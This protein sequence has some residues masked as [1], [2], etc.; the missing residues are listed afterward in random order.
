MCCCL[1]VVSVFDC[2]WQNGFLP[3]EGCFIKLDDYFSVEEPRPVAVP[4]VKATVT[5]AEH[6]SQQRQIVSNGTAAAAADEDAQT[7]GSSSE[8]DSST[9][10]EESQQP[11]SRLQRTQQ[12]SGAAA[13]TNTQRAP[14]PS[15]TAATP[16]KQAP[17]SQRRSTQPK[18][19]AQ[20]QS[21]PQSKQLRR[22]P[23]SPERRS[24]EVDNNC[25]RVS[26]ATKAVLPEDVVTAVQGYFSMQF[27]QQTAI[28]LNS[29]GSR[30][31]TIV[32]KLTFL[33]AVAHY[34]RSA[35]ASREAVIS[36]LDTAAQD[37]VEFVT[38]GKSTAVAVF[39]VRCRCFTVA[40]I[41]AAAVV[42]W[43][44]FVL[45]WVLAVVV[46][47]LLL[48]LLLSQEICLLRSYLICRKTFL[49]M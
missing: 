10:A 3:S 46:F 41:G 35:T 30:S 6:G 40:R 49:C 47:L 29:A 42:L 27:V 37:F 16:S 19:S 32:R 9:D 39:S 7:H 38:A 24:P 31:G 28:A 36:H 15:G 13:T 44:E 33:P 2:I 48:L 45:T 26:E 23:V 34:L 22:D 14:P 20:K 1:F 43:S 18:Q 21:A 17:S 8:V 4:S 25:F 5:A 11:P 12:P